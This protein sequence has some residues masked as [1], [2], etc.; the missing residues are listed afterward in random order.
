MVLAIMMILFAAAASGLK[1]SWQ[2]Q[3]IRASAIHLAHD[4]ALATQTAAKFNKP[5]ELRFYKYYDQRVANEMPQFFGWQLLMRE[6]SS[7]DAKGKSTPLYELQRCEGT[8]VM[9]QHRIGSS[10]CSTI[11][12]TKSI[13]PV[14]QRDPELGNGPYEFVSVEFSPSGRTN[15]DPD[16]PEPWTITMIPITWVD[17]PGEMPKEFQVVGLDA[18]SG[19]VRIW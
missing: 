6:P 16:A 5:V 17:H 9:S 13:Q 18:R 3:E 10:M 7:A 4:I 2:G 11:L 1:K 12:N 15:L 14:P 8:T 19:A